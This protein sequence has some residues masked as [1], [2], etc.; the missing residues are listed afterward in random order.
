MIFLGNIKLNI[1]IFSLDI[2]LV[3]LYNVM[4]KFTIIISM[5]YYL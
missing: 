1:L 4:S 2:Q 5:K 3:I